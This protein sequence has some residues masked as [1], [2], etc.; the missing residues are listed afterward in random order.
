MPAHP[1]DLAQAASAHYFSPNTALLSPEEQGRARLL[2]V[3]MGNLQLQFLTGA[4][5]FS[6]SSL[7]E[8]SALLVEVLL[9]QGDFPGAARVCDLGCG[10][11]V[12]GALWAKSNPAHRVL[13]LDVNP[14]A[15]QLAKLNYAHNA[16]EN[17]AAWCGDGLAAARGEFFDCVAFNPPIRAGN[18]V[19]ERLLRDAHRT[20]KPRGELWAVIRTAQGA[21]TWAKKLETLFGLN[22]TVQ[23]RAGY[24]ILKATKC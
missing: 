9:Q 22:E 15:V 24:R 12:V 21:K 6:K 23:M 17:A 2:P 18:A 11:G 14:R 1:R 19:I 20:L 3:K 7:D 8:G 4:G 10:W 5:T 13:A 16:I